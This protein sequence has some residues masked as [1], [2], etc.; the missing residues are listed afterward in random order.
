MTDSLSIFVILVVVASFSAAYGCLI[1][2]I[3]AARKAASIVESRLPKFPEFVAV[4]SIVLHS[5]VTFEDKACS[6]RQTLKSNTPEFTSVFIERWC[7]ERGLVIQPKGK[8]FEV[9]APSTG[10]Q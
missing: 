3:V 1:G 10:A 5:D 9:K 7:E 8:D 4:Q 6:I 2:L